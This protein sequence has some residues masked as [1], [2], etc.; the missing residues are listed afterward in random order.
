[1]SAIGISAKVR[2]KP[3]M[4]PNLRRYAKNLNEIVVLKALNDCMTFSSTL[5]RVMRMF[6]CF[7]GEFWTS[8]LD[9]TVA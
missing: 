1:M 9:V 8:T 7:G 6:L 3:K 5:V 4:G 2:Q